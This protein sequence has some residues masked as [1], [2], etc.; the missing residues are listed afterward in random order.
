VKSAF[1]LNVVVLEGSA[2]LEL[3][4]GENQ[5]LL[6]RRDSFFVLDLGLDILD[7]VALLDVEGDGVFPVRVLTKICICVEVVF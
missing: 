7:R 6:V 3:L 5:T 2:V 1:L 4:S